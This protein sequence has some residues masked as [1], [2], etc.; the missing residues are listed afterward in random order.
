MEKHLE[1][2]RNG[3][4][5]DE[6]VRATRAHWRR[7]A[8]SLMRKWKCPCDVE[9]EDLVQEMLM[10]VFVFIP[11]YDPTRGTTLSQYV[12]WNANNRA[13][14]WIHCQRGALRRDDKARSRHPIAMSRLA[15][16]GENPVF[17]DWLTAEGNQEVDSE[18]ARHVAMIDRIFEGDARVRETV[19]II[20]RVDGDLVAAA[21]EILIR[22]RELGL[23]VM[24]YLEAYRLARKVVEALIAA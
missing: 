8:I 11:K 1:R 2:L 15:A 17:D 7:M 19:R 10:A 20:I 14:K 23:R 3:G 9:V 18:K 22:R 24:S 21:R 13:K 5:F 4:S 12:T 16:P 6:F